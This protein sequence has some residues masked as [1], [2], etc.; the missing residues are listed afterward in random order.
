MK[1]KRFAI[2]YLPLFASS[3][4]SAAAN[5]YL[6][7]EVC[8][9]CHKDI[10]LTQSQ[11]N[12]AHTWQGAVS[13]QLPADYSETHSEG[14]QPEIHYAIKKAGGTFEYQVQM[15]GQ[16]PLEYPVEAIVGGKRHG[17]SFLLRASAF[18]DSPLPKA[19]LIEARYFHSTPQDR[20]AFSLGFPED[21]PQSYET[22][23]G[24]VLMPYL[25]Q[26][27][28]ACHGSPR[29]W[30]AT[31]EHGVSC[32][33]CHGP[34]RPHLAAFATHSKNLGILNPDKLPVAEQW[35]PCMQC[36]AGSS[37]VADP[38]PDDLLISDQVTALSNSEC[39]RESGGQITCTNCHNPHQ[40]APRPVLEAR[41]VKTCLRCHSTAVAK[42]AAIC[43]VNRTTGCVG[44]HMPDQ[45][46]GAFVIADHWVRVHPEQNVKATVHNPAWRTSITPKHLFL[47]IIVM[48]DRE[49]AEFVSQQLRAGGSFFELAR[50]NSIDRG[51]AMSGGYLGDLE[52]SKLDPAWSAAALKLQPGEVSRVIAANGKYVLLGRMPRNFREDA[53]AI[54]NQAMELRKQNKPQE[55]VNQL[56]ESLKIYPHLL[57]ALT[58]LGAM[59][60]QAGNPSV[61]A[62][63]LSM[64]ARLYPKDGG[65]H[66]NLALAYG[67]MGNPDEITEYQR[68][69][70]IDPDYVLAYLN[71]G[72]ALYAKGQYDEAIKIY[73]QG[74]NVN[75]LFAAL[76]YS[77]GLA[78]EKQ[79]KGAEAQAEMALAKKIDPNTG[80]P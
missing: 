46:R 38:L 30:G 60:G 57:R 19:F 51:T 79:N 20:L 65:T 49:K 16:P 39:W 77:L 74:I 18:E 55:A 72:S 23:F 75:P 22:A 21:K 66:Y 10:A 44:C 50:T 3:L 15:P 36:H 35:R 25:E 59:Y 29:K 67:A 40:D 78:L 2:V 33:N 43:P 8:A 69:I 7:R 47:R 24:R 32:E 5:G 52:A 1:F 56:I 63:V 58:W 4:A 45:I 37:Y 11:T 53:E 70:E 76:H 73:R 6:G 12:M 13:P 71:W 48:D 9:G 14:P 34:G 42:H 26:R 28:L 62:G 31:V 41:A 64:A 61:S 68:T 80:Q 27:C 54:F 17:L